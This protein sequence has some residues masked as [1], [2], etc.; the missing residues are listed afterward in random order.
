[1]ASVCPSFACFTSRF[2]SNTPQHAHNTAR[3]TTLPPP[4]WPSRLRLPPPFH[5]AGCPPM[6]H[7]PTR[8]A[9]PPLQRAAGRRPASH[10]KQQLLL[11]PRCYCCCCC[12]QRRLQ[13]Q[14]WRLYYWRP[15]C[16]PASCAQ[17][18]PHC[19]PWRPRHCC[20]CCCCPGCL[21]SQH[22]CRRRRCCCCP[23]RLQ[24]QGCAPARAAHWRAPER[25]TP[26]PPPPHHPPPRPQSPRPRGHPWRRPP[27]PGTP[28]CA[29]GT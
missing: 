19:C 6:P 7:R 17:A 21:H 3:L 24:A 27:G 15:R 11:P 28:P 25:G 14:R 22:Q 13:A 18:S 23:R 29:P 9:A 8:P 26:W 5:S 16:P 10:W 2:P 4:C 1:M 20:C 12:C